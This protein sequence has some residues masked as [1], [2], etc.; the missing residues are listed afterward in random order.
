MYDSF[1]GGSPVECEPTISVVS[2]PVYTAAYSESSN[3]SN[4][5]QP[6]SSTNYQST[7]KMKS[8]LSDDAL[9]SLRGHLGDRSRDVLEKQE[10]RF[11][12]FGRI[13]AVKMRDLGTRQRILVEKLINDSLFEAEL[14]HLTES[15]KVVDTSRSTRELV[16]SEP[17]EP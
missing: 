6:S 9:V 15:Y 12:I 8:E 13:V 7:K 2:S 1:A 3:S 5:R 17:L 11:D 4:C 14:G 10:D 16:K